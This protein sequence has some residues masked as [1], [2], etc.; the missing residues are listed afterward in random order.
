MQRR[1]ALTLLAVTA[2]GLMTT[3]C[4]SM[5]GTSA[6]ADQGPPFRTTS[7]A[8][9]GKLMLM[10]HD[11]VAYFTQ[12]DAVAGN[13]AIQAE[14]MG[15]TWRFASEANKTEFLREPARYMP[16]FGGYC[17]NGI[18]YA[19]PWGAGGG[20]NTWRIYRGKLYVFGGQ[21]SRDQFEM[22]TELNLQRAHQYWTSEIAGSNPLWVRY[23]RMVFRV[24]HYK[25][26]AALQAEWEARRAAGTL[27]VMP[28]G[29]QVVPAQP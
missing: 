21:S 18:N 22:E 19:V 11:P 7:D 24:P 28:G 3:G 12:N 29:K 17:S 2:A 15:V 25:S 1:H 26:D 13:P 5:A 8:H 4:A 6:T 10:G 23:K 14:H 20:P 9:A 27:P 16:Q